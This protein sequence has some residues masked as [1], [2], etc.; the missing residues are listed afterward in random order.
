[1]KTR[2]ERI[3]EAVKLGY[4]L[5]P[6]HITWESVPAIELYKYISKMLAEPIARRLGWCLKVAKIIED[7]GIAKR[8]KRNGHYWFRGIKGR[9]GDKSMT[10]RMRKQH[11]KDKR[12]YRKRGGVH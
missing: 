1:M 12:A 10:D 5:C 7:A 6:N 3:I 4:E 8:I 2:E 9:G 11:Q